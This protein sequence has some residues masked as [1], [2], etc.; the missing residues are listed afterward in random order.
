METLVK[1]NQAY[2]KTLSYCEET[3]IDVDNEYEL[4]MQEL[5]ELNLF[6]ELQLDLLYGKICGLN[7]KVKNVGT[8]KLRKAFVDYVIDTET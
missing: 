3:C 6:S 8:R 4:F 7:E 5:Y 1:R 2:K